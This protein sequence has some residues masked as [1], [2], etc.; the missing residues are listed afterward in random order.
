MKRIN[1]LQV[2]NSRVY[3]GN[4]EHIRALIKYLD[5]RKFNVLTAIPESSEF[6]A[7]LK[8]EGIEIAYNEI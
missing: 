7:V 2:S 8:N 3:G 4:E 5:K 6:G 1:I